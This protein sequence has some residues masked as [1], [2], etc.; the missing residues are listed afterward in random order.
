M[1]RAC[2]HPWT[3][4]ALATLGVTLVLALLIGPHLRGASLAPRASARTASGPL[5]ML[6]QPVPAAGGARPSG[7]LAAPLRRQ[8]TQAA[9]PTPPF[10]VT[11]A[12]VELLDATTGRVLYRHQ[13]MLRF[14]IAST[15][16]VMT[17][18]LA[19][20]QGS[21]DRVVTIAPQD[22]PD[23]ALNAAVVGFQPGQQ[24]TV[25]QLLYGLA[26]ASGYDAAMAIAR[27][28]GGSVPAFIVQMNRRAQELGMHDTHFLNPAGYAVGVASG[29][30][31]TA[32]DMAVLMCI[33]AQHPD[34]VQIFGTIQHTLPATATHPAIVLDRTW[35][36][37][38]PDAWVGAAPPDARAPVRNLQLPFQVL[39]VKK[40]C[41]DCDPADHQL[42]Y[43]VLAH[44][45]ARRIVGA[46][47][48]TTQYYYDPHVGD[49]LPLL[50]WAFGDCG[51]AQARGFC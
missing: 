28:V 35:G 7:C 48:G 8:S 18:L 30:Y 51:T 5:A 21:L 38:L 17:A 14:Q 44:Q 16:K 1:R 23:P 6:R 47:V 31:S 43:V 12:G 49:M 9:F 27:T 13:P 45:G 19:S 20:E 50:L 2:L 36:T 26:L 24:Y 46:F 32:Q 10:P 22:L 39:A 37:T 33:V 34:L 41:M 4:R 42:S 40:G 29:H 11:T 25:R 15:T 3:R